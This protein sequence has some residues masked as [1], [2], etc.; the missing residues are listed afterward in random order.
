MF[1][2]QINTSIKKMRNFFNG[3]S[4]FFNPSLSKNIFFPSELNSDFTRHF[5]APAYYLKKSYSVEEKKYS[6]QQKKK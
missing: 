2:N 5:N 6:Q 3:I 4:L 1:E